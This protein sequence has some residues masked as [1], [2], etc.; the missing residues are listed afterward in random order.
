MKQILRNT[1]TS[2]YAILI[3]E[4]CRPST[5]EDLHGDVIAWLPAGV[6]HVWEEPDRHVCRLWC[7]DAETSQRG[8]SSHR[9]VLTESSKTQVEFLS[10][11][12]VVKGCC[13]D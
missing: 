10:S 3:R 1:D 4:Q 9:N 2:T 12:I 7:Y 5:C 6:S 11:Y 8:P 13:G